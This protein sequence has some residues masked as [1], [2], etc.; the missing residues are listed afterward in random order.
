MIYSWRRS[1]K[2]IKYF[3]LGYSFRSFFLDIWFP[4]LLFRTPK[5]RTA[6]ESNPIGFLTMGT[7][8]ECYVNYSGFNQ[9]NKVTII[10]GMPIYNKI[11]N[12]HG[13]YIFQF[14][15]WIFNLSFSTLVLLSKFFNK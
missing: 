12:I 10:P 3:P 13:K 2:I 11:L 1:Y 9:V 7:H 5:H 15:A 4:F 14:G 8:N 6:K